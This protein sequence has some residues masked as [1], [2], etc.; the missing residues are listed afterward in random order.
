MH[1]FHR[2][3]PSGTKC[4]AAVRPQKA[5][6]VSESGVLGSSN[7]PTEGTATGKITSIAQGNP[8]YGEDVD[9]KIDNT[10]CSKEYGILQDCLD[11]TDK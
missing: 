7:Q 11:E 4:P 6:E 10:G 5:S 9:E 3:D 8:H 1:L 2:K